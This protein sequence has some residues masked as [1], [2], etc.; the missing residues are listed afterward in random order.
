MRKPNK[1]LVTHISCSHANR[2]MGLCFFCWTCFIRPFVVGGSTFDS[3]GLAY[4]LH[5]CAIFFPLCVCVCVCDGVCCVR[6]VLY[7][8]CPCPPTVPNRFIGTN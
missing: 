8:L 7:A 6:L 2:Y 5:M 1:D 4:F 3:F